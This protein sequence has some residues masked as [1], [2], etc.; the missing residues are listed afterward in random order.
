[1]MTLV[2]DLT[3]IVDKTGQKH[4]QQLHRNTWYY[5]ATC[6]AIGYVLCRT[7]VHNEEA[8]AVFS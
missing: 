1:M 2:V 7:E 3:K 6:Q 4:M 5:K 8:I